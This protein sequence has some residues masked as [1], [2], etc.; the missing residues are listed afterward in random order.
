MRTTP[1]CGQQ[2]AWACLQAGAPSPLVPAPDQVQPIIEQTPTQRAAVERERPDHSLADRPSLAR[3]PVPATL[4][5]LSA[6]QPAVPPIV[7]R[8]ELATEKQGGGQDTGS[9]SLRTS[10]PPA[11][12][13]IHVTIGRIEVRATQPPAPVRRSAPTASTMSL[14]DYLRSR[15]RKGR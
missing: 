3:S 10:P 15:T 8:M 4:G 14:E 12:P 11:P 6:A 13:T 1:D 7:E 2:V 9:G 5:A